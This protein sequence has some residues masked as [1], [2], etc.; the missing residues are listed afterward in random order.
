MVR[1]TVEVKIGSSNTGLNARTVLFSVLGSK[2]AGRQVSK[3]ITA[4]NKRNYKR[5]KTVFECA[6]CAG[7]NVS[8]RPSLL[9]FQWSFSRIFFTFLF[10][11]F[12][13]P[14][15]QG[16]LSGVPTESSKPATPT[17]A[18][19][20]TSNVNRTEKEQEDVTAET[21]QNIPDVA[22][23]VG[24]DG[25]DDLD[26]SAPP[27]EPE[28][29]IDTALAITDSTPDAS[30]AATAALA[31]IVR[32]GSTTKFYPKSSVAAGEEGRA[33]VRVCVNKRGRVLGEPVIVESTGYQALDE[34]AVRLAKAGRYRA[35]ETEQGVK[36]D[37]SCVAFAVAF[38]LAS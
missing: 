23:N 25:N 30:P 27:G 6:S 29:L 7:S 37:E 35:G 32:M 15:C 8:A 36:Q 34:G 1:T 28:D 26:T 12:A 2:Q 22:P 18:A 3:F 4:P 17:S 33:V 38:K 9:S 24:D 5:V 16:F 20:N 19:S 14:F 10:F 13:V 11:L 21:N 31:T